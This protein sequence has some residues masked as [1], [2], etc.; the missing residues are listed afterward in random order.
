VSEDLGSTIDG[1]RRAPGN[2]FLARI[3]RLILGRSGI[4]DYIVIGDGS[5][6]DR[7]TEARRNARLQAGKLISVR[8]RF[9]ADCIIRDRTKNGAR[10]KLAKHAPLRKEMLF[11]DDQ[12]RA[13]CAASIIWR[14]GL[15]VGCVMSELPGKDKS[16]FIAALEQRYYA[17]K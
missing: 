1:M 13:I 11:Y 3:S 15:N 8:G 14:Q 4:V 16:K 9:V 7:R 12:T 2:A 17:M 10:L 5:R 6:Q